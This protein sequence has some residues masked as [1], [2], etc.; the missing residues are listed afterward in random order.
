[1]CGRRLT[2]AHGASR[3]SPG[4][5][6]EAASARSPGD[7]K[8]EGA[9]GV[10]RV[11]C[12]RPPRLRPAARHN[13]IRCY[14]RAAVREDRALSDAEGDHP[15]PR[16]SARSEYA[17][18]HAM[19]A[20]LQAVLMAC[21]TRRHDQLLAE[22]SAG[23]ARPA[24]RPAVCRSQPRWPRGARSIPREDAEEAFKTYA[25]AADAHRA[26]TAGTAACCCST[27]ASRC[28]A[29]DRAC[30]AASPRLSESVGYGCARLR[31][32]PV[33]RCEA[34]RNAAQSDNHLHAPGS[35]RFA[36]V[37]TRARRGSAT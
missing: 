25:E 6:A 33:G 30:P 18:P 13:R 37:G 19:L 14:Y 1:M 2:T 21:T 26:R 16:A 24:A 35:A 31:Q 17:A 12:S 8:D 4:D 29:A 5:D 32:P 20:D 7:G 36:T 15:P 34:A 11:S 23:R 27:G 10:P 3:E 22:A 9:W 28:A